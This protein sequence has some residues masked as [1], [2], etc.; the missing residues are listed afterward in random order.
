MNTMNR[1][2]RT[3]AF[4]QGAMVGLLVLLVVTAARAQ[5][6][7]PPAPWR[8]AGSPPCV[9]SD[10]GI[11]KCAPAVQTIAVRAGHLFDSKNGTMLT[12]QVIVLSGEKITDVGPEGQVK[13]PAGAQVIDL[14]QATVLPGLIDGHT[15]M[16]DARKPNVTTEQAMT[17]AISN[18]QA[19]LRAGFTAAR[20]MT[21]HGNGYGDIAIRDAINQGRIDGPRYQVS[22]LGIVW[23]A[24]PP[25]PAAPDNPLASTVVRSVEDARAAVR[26]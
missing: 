26:E 23:G 4:A 14:S 5:L 8:G 17:I 19:N 9:G 16:F 20:D 10:G 1:H 3:R 25:N 15:H 7:P 13:I 2:V 21:S 11:Y 6:Q 18:V 24:K 12:K 22:T